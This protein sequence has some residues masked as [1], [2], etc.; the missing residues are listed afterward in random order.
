MLPAAE[1][2]PDW[3]R[4][5]ESATPKTTVILTYLLTY[6]LN[7]LLTSWSRV[8][9]EKLTGSQTV[10]KFSAYY[11]TECSLPHLQVPATCTY[12]EPD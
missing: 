9:F 6:V 3:R 7:Y 4:E 10:K 11:G 5:S 12:P 1:G 2:R 8:V